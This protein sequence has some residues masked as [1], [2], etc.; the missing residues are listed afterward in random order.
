MSLLK[1]AH[2]H[3]W[4]DFYSNHCYWKVPLLRSPVILF[5]KNLCT[6]T[7]KC[8]GKIREK[9]KISSLY[10]DRF[11]A[12]R[13]TQKHKR[14]GTHKEK[15][16][17]EKKDSRKTQTSRWKK[18]IETA[19]QWWN[20]L[21]IALNCE[22]KWNKNRKFSLFLRPFIQRQFRFCSSV[23]IFSFVRR[24][25]SKVSL[26]NHFF[27]SP[28][29]RELYHRYRQTDTI[30]CVF[31]VENF[32]FN[33]ILL[34]VLRIWYFFYCCLFR[35]WL[36]SSCF[37][38]TARTEMNFHWIGVKNLLCECGTQTHSHTHTRLH[39]SEKALSKR[40]P[41]RIEPKCNTLT[42][43]FFWFVFWS[44]AV[45]WYVLAGASGMDVI[46]M[47]F[48]FALWQ[49]ITQRSRGMQAERFCESR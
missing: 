14:C 33:L 6:T 45:F 9:N 46:R 24:T 8:C 41:N 48:W 25:P 47:V 30:Y 7:R 3:F 21:K 31:L 42:I 13:L 49:A 32:S 19:A 12:F 40:E 28:L 18:E 15:I 17:N 1:N 26:F 23:Q 43:L 34:L 38:S 11:V 29:S 39:E 35:W 2:L 27:C 37:F 10:F 4:H 5:E 20:V 44:P 22:I 16:T 36:E